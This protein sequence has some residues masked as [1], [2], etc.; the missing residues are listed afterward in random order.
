[1][2]GHCTY[3]TFCVPHSSFSVS[4][5]GQILLPLFMLLP[6]SIAHTNDFSSDSW[7]KLLLPCAEMT[8][9]PCRGLF[10]VF[11]M[12]FLSRF[13]LHKARSFSQLSSGSPRISRQIPSHVCCASRE[14]TTVSLTWCVL[15]IALINS[16]TPSCAYQWEGVCCPVLFVTM[17]TASLNQVLHQHFPHLGD[18]THTFK[19][20]Y[21]QLE[22]ECWTFRRT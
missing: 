14:T 19:N 4:Q 1:M 3:K 21:Q 18:K 2:T 15:T 17:V 11:V 5:L 8:W 9:S 10:Q 16:A 22:W 6:Y 12:T 20:V 7:N 13:I